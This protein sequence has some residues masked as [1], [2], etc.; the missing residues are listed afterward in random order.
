MFKKVFS[1][2]L[3]VVLAI[4]L[5]AFSFNAS[6]VTKFSD[7]EG[8]KNQTAIE[9]LEHKEILHGND[10][11]TFKPDTGINR[12]EVLKVLYFLIGEHPA[13]PTDKCFPDVP[14]DL[15]Y[16]KYVCGGKEA[17]Y[18]HGYPDGNFYP[19]K[20]INKVEVLKLIGTFLE[21]DLSEGAGEVMFSDADADLWYADYLL[22]AKKKNYLEYYGDVFHPSDEMMRG[23]VAEVI[24]RSILSDFLNLEKYDEQHV[25]TFLKEMEV[26]DVVTYKEEEAEGEDGEKEGEGEDEDD[27]KEGEG[28]G[29]G[30]SDEGDQEGESDEE[31]GADGDGQ[32]EDGVSTKTEDSA[33]T[34]VVDEMVDGTPGA[35]WVGVYQYEDKLI[36][37]DYFSYLDE[38]GDGQVVDVG[39][40]EEL[41]FFWLDLQ[42]YAMFGHEATIVTVNANTGTYTEY[43][44]IMWPSINGMEFY[45]TANERQN[46]THLR[47]KGVSLVSY[48]LH[49]ETDSS[50]DFPDFGVCGADPSERKKAIVLYVGT[51]PVIK[52]N[53]VNM[54]N[55]L[56]RQDYV[57]TVI[58]GISST[59]VMT[60]IEDELRDIEAASHIENYSR[61]LFHVSSHALTNGDLFVDSTT[62][63][64]GSSKTVVVD[65]VDLDDLAEKWGVIGFEID[66]TGIWTDSFT[67][68]HDTS[69]SGN[70][71][72]KYQTEAYIPGSRETAVGWVAAASEDDQPAYATKFSQTGYYF[73]KALINCMGDYTEYAGFS[74]CVVDKTSTL[75]TGPI[76][77]ISQGPMIEKLSPMTDDAVPF[78]QDK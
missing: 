55:Y 31:G 53:A 77:Y 21:W 65:S 76:P 66:I 52:R 2:I 20:K 11:G 27:E 13:E 56:C 36:S 60:D 18:L 25:L 5:F 16:T 68:I 12:A 46:S 58:E 26:S 9:Y 4:S 62:T 22:Y 42:P 15:W 75:V 32:A 17:G 44:T 48:F 30:D 57:V 34:F 10:D 19:E 24:F 35:E 3:L 63:G 78:I 70:A 67:I 38:N 73:T 23:E 71:I 28:E 50:T 59:Q 54:Y 47:Y 69:Y 49:L 64:S 51:D 14:L 7:I 29:E 40:E 74:E 1:R 72:L 8:H 39:A 43:S 37:G 61:I 45:D 41:W 6:A 33:L